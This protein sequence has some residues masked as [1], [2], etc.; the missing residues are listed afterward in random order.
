MDFPRIVTVEQNFD[1]LNTPKDHPSRRETDT[2]Y[3]DEFHI[4]RTQTTTMW[5][6]YLRDPEVLEKDWKKR[7]MLSFVNWNCF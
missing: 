4:L 6:F 7:A 3:L 1:V 2:Y 5:P